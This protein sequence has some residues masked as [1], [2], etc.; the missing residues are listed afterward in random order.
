MVEPTHLKNISQKGSP[1]QVRVKKRG[2]WNHQ[3]VT[4][5]NFC[6]MFLR[7]G[8]S[9][10]ITI[11]ALWTFHGCPAGKCWRSHGLVSLFWFL[12]VKLWTPSTARLML[13]GYIYIPEIELCQL[14]ASHSQ[15]F[16][17]W[18]VLLPWW[19]CEIIID[20]LKM[21]GFT[22]PLVRY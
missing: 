19:W 11:Q 14:T 15:H 22:D 1:P 9:M 7:P 17:S 6:W 20:M 12:V 16:T 4:V 10:V 13:Y 21:N 3:P 18:G 2:I 8:R 5:A